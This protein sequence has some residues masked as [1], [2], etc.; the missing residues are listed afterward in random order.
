METQIFNHAKIKSLKTPLK[1][2]KILQDIRI[3]Y[4]ISSFNTSQNII[5]QKSSHKNKPITQGPK[6][7]TLLYSIMN[8]N[9]IS[10]PWQARPTKFACYWLVSLSMQGFILSGTFAWALALV[11]PN[12]SGFTQGAPS[13]P[14][15]ILHHARSFIASNQIRRSKEMCG[16]L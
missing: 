8:L 15:R 14:L 1:E 9:M 3:L 6:S 11:K 13:F 7:F 16:L 4:L 5:F 12:T 10:L 2:T